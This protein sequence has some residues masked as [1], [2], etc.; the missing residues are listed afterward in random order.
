[1]GLVAAVAYDKVVD[2]FVDTVLGDALE[3][4]SHYMSAL[5]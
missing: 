2:S 5:L 1:M 4:S 3:L